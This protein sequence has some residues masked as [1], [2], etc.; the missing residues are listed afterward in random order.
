MTSSFTGR[1]LPGHRAVRSVPGGRSALH[2]LPG[3]RPAGA[4]AAPA[5]LLRLRHTLHR[6]RDEALQPGT[7]QV[8]LRLTGLDYD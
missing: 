6:R 1:E 5:L 8:R 7:T 2:P 3:H 4:P